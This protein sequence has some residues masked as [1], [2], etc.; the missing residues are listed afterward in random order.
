MLE[1]GQRKTGSR[2]MHGP[3]QDKEDNQEPLIIIN[4]NKMKKESQVSY[5]IPYATSSAATLN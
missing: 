4:D 5:N 3:G 1:A 2:A